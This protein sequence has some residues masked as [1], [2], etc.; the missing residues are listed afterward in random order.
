V[1]VNWQ[2]L[3]QVLV[4]KTGQKIGRLEA[5]PVSG[6]DINRAWRLSDGQLQYFIKTNTPER[7]AM[8]E[9]EMIGLK[10][11]QTSN[12]IRVPEALACGIVG[13][14]AFIV[15]EYL[16]LSGRP[17]PVRLA[18]QLAA[19]HQCTQ[20]QYGFAVEN[21]IGSTPQINRFTG[22]WPVF[23]Q[24]HRLGYQ[25]S[26]AK[27]NGYGKELLD[28]GMRLNEQ[29]GHFFSGYTPLASLLHGDL[30][31]GNQGADSAGNPVIYDPAC[32]YGDHETDLAMM[33]LFGGPGQRF[34]DA[35]DELFAIDAGYFTRRE[36]YNLYHILNHAN[37]FG[38]SYV[39]QAKQM[40][41]SL[42]AQV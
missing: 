38:V 16:E 15:M 4:D 1:T 8:F 24:Q 20:D 41:A 35:Y 21:T 29:V 28:T 7:L 23:W 25:L 18:R 31:S 26:L 3:Q 6:G 11:I 39:S 27:M 5:S 30:W 19:M 32:Y 13:H 14:Q 9:A 42:L 34:F 10:A 22:D 2:Q 33:E 12:S 40:I 36:L 37:L 17:D